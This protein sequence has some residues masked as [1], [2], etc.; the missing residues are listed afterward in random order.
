MSDKKDDSN[1]LDSYGVWVKN[2][3]LDINGEPSNS[4][5]NS[6]GEF[7]LPD[8][9]EASSDEDIFKDLDFTSTAEDLQ[10]DNLDDGETALNPDELANIVMEADTQISEEEPAQSEGI[11][12]EETA[13]LSGA[14]FSDDPDLPEEEPFND[15]PFAKDSNENSESGEIESAQIDA[16]EEIQPEQKT[17]DETKSEETE[18]SFE[19][20][21]IDLDAF[22]GDSGGSQEI[23]FDDGEIDLGDFM[24]GDFSSSAPSKEPAEIKDEQTLDIDVD[25]D[26]EAETIA[27]E[28]TPENAAAMNATSTHSGN[29]PNAQGDTDDEMFSSFDAAVAAQGIPESVPSGGTE[30]QSLSDS[31]EIDLSEFGFDDDDSKIG[32]TEGPDGS[33]PIKKEVIN[34]VMKVAADDDTD[35]P[36]VKDVI[37]GKI[38][39][40]FTENDSEEDY[41][42]DT[43]ENTTS[44]AVSP[45]ISEKGKEILEQIMAE[46]SSLRDEIK[47]IKTEFADMQNRQPATAAQDIPQDLAAQDD[48]SDG[49]FGSD[50]GDNTIALSGSEMTDILNSAEITQA[51]EGSE[52][53]AE[54]KSEIESDSMEEPQIEENV[55][56]E[57]EENAISEDELGIPDPTLEGLSEDFTT[58]MQISDEIQLEESALPDE[59]SV[60]TSETFNNDAMDE[61]M[62]E[63]T[64]IENSL[65]EDNLSYLAS[66]SAIEKDAPESEAETQDKT[67]NVDEIMQDN[68]SLQ[69][70]EEA[71]VGIGDDINA[72]FE[73][74]DATESD[75]I[76]DSLAAKDN[77]ENSVSGIMQENISHQEGEEASVG[78][79]D[80]INA[81]FEEADATESDIIDDSLAAKDAYEQEINKNIDNESEAPA[82]FEEPAIGECISDENAAEDPAVVEPLTENAEGTAVEEP[83]I[84]TIGEN[85]AMTEEASPA[86]ENYE[87]E[88]N[89]TIDDEFK[90]PVD[91][92]EP[93][94]EDAVSDENTAEPIVAEP[95]PEDAE[96]TSVEEP[97]I[98][99]TLSDENAVEE[100]S[101]DENEKTQIDQT[102]QTSIPKNLKEEVI[103][104]LSYMDQL[105]ENLPE[106]KITEF[107]K[108]EHFATYKKLFDELGLS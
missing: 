103:S 83:A 27:V 71:S 81:A 63:D 77:F 70:G 108:S 37:S 17:G 79:G 105:L 57:I 82:D 19:D 18:I 104:V 106:E 15:E 74:A 73:E 11:T 90:E 42:T 4:S 107:A 40:E 102:Q 25:F 1:E 59:I 87:Q 22:M 45:E 58:P 84:P 101:S 21:E 41:N 67:P 78:I 80:D 100:A 2:S 54:P 72:A 62:S 97:T 95:L 51:E 94:I 69:E 39:A 43:M 76:D 13:A 36:S 60:P 20:G 96:E 75:I 5:E 52:D 10:D 3:P 23:S 66:D 14:F 29:S 28:D 24:G 86:E 49:F 68:I 6:I 65:T 47:N 50:D 91:F 55:E 12:D 38:S 93:I 33:N 88:I 44:N 98:A 61:Y 7:D 34:Y 35:T 53:F 89:K 92:E 9:G 48:D 32:M 31:D 30:S 16:T 85:V 26:G 8:L 64:P 46:L 99:E 56:Q